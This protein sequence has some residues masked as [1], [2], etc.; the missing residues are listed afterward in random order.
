MG[1]TASRLIIGKLVE[2]S[3]H[4]LIDLLVNELATCLRQSDRREG[5]G[6]IELNIRATGSLSLDPEKNSA[7]PD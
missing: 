7:A 3:F 4:L 6:G 1:A 5:A 2:R